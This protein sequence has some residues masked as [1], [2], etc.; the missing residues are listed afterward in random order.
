MDV[1]APAEVW[2]EIKDAT[3]VYVVDS[4]GQ[5]RWKTPKEV[6]PEDKVILKNTGEPITMD[7]DIG[8]PS[9]EKGSEDDRKNA[10][11]EAAEEAIGQLIA[12]RNKRRTKAVARDKLRRVTDKDPDSSEVM[13][14]VLKELAGEQAAMKFEREEHEREGKDISEIS[15]RRVRILVHLG[16]NWMKRQERLRDVGIVDLNSPAMGAFVRSIIETLEATMAELHVGTDA[17][18]SILNK[19]AG[20]LDDE[21]KL[22]TQKRMKKAAE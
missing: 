18:N 16:E 11:Q 19:L 7:G 6:S 13:D 22:A 10:V 15:A 21:W 3:R 17:R 20:R 5:K 12:D 2:D 9:N 8:R 14:L 4:S 1:A